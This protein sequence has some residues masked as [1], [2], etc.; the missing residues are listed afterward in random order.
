LKGKKILFLTLHTF[1][2]TGGI[3]K[4]SRAF[5]K[6]LSDLKKESAIQ[7][8]Q[9]NSLYDTQA[10]LRYVQKNSFKGFAGKKIFFGLRTLSHGINADVIVLSHIN[11]LLFAWLIKKIKPQK[12]IV[13]FAH[14][15]EIWKKLSPWKTIFIKNNV[16]IWAVSNF[17]ARRV[18]EVHQIS[19]DQ[20]KVLNNCL[21]PFFSSPSHF[22]KP[23]SLLERYGL[24]L[25]TKI[26]F[27]LGRLSSLE[28]Y[29][30]YDQVLMALKNFPDAHYILAGKADD[31]EKKRIKNL[32]NEYGLQNR[33]TLTGFIPDSEII[34][35]YLLAD[36]FV[37][38]SKGE[39]FGISFI[40]AVACGCRVIAG[41]KDGSVD[42]LLHGN[43]GDLVD[44]DDSEALSNAILKNISKE[45][46]KSLNLQKK[47][48]A[49]FD[50]V[51]YKRNVLEL[52]NTSCLHSQ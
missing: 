20:I 29:K 7:D 4:V 15:I 3:E 8:Y 23:V 5:A 30:G 11:L 17:T 44:P 39:G 16:E 26:L 43:L 2:L 49:S 14:G 21:D 27:T 34:A 46:T 37:M 50:F 52:L 25:S 33:V 38:P 24:D 35:H 10:D 42:A 36:I 18:A 12:K 40:E 47:C 41:N 9:V 1:S 13:L 28:Q 31:Q 32:I 22:N 19:A 48:L 45:R 51:G 6:V